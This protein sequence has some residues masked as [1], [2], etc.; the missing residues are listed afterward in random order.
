MHS[1][2]RTDRRVC[3]RKVFCLGTVVAMILASVW[4]GAAASLTPPRELLPLVAS[5]REGKCRSYLSDLSVLSQRPDPAGSRAAYLLGHCLAQAGQFDAAKTAFDAV[6]ARFPPLASYARFYAAQMT[7]QIGASEETVARLN[8]TLAGTISPPLA[9]RAR[10]MRAET[11]VRLGRA[12]EAR[13]ALKEFLADST[14]DESTARA[15]WLMGLATEL[16]GDRPL[17]IQAYGMAWWAMPDTASSA[18]AAHRLRSLYAGRLP[19][20]SPEARVA[21]ARHLMSTGRR[22][23]AE[24]ELVSALHRGVTGATAGEAWYRLGL[25]RLG[26]AHAVFALEQAV[27]YEPGSSRASYWLGRALGSAGRVAEEKSVWRTLINSNPSSPWAPRSLF[28]LAESA[29]D[30]QAWSE[31]DRWLSALVERYPASP[32]ADEARWRRGWMRYRLGQY[33]QAEQFFSRAATEFPR[34]AR[35]AANLYWAA[36]ARAQQGRDARFLLELAAVRYPLTFYGQR[37]R[38]RLALP[39]PVPAP[40]PPVDVLSDDRAYE[41]SEELAALGFDQDA[42]DEADATLPQE[43][44]T[45]AYRLAALL[46]ARTGDIYKSIGAAGLAVAPALSGG[47]SVDRGLWTLAYPRA[48]WRIVS[49]SAQQAGVDPYL[50]LAVIRE[51]SRFDPTAVSPAGAVGLMQLLASTAQG[52]AGAPVTLQHLTDPEDNIRYGAGYL[53]G[54][55]RRFGGD[56]VLALAA[57]NAGPGAAHRFARLPRTDL[58]YFIERIP[59]P[60]TRAYVQRVMQ[61]YGIYR[62]LYREAVTSP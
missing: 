56:P 3:A 58:D 28:A 61:S 24:Q 40:S 23:D 51:E 33:A 8:G 14:G 19:D 49:A 26:T 27:R 43:A 60:E 45:E 46:R 38:Q 32:S 34:A 52:I 41:T 11:L 18:D 37:A 42:A 4:P 54:M 48:H 22:R 57:Y 15:W 10:L 2:R 21:R 13:D 30:E 53:G 12:A 29:E 17:A 31:A 36:K 62:W 9:R 47:A 7:Q 35:A 6:A 1:I 50:V 16:M 44:E 25:L 59:Y 5:F 20:P 55:L 39:P